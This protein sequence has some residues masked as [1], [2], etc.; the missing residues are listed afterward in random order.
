[1]QANLSTKSTF[2]W[3]AQRI[4]AIFLVFFLC[5]HINFNHLIA[6]ELGEHGYSGL[7]NFQFVQSRL[8]SGS[9]LWSIFYFAFIPICV[10]HAIN[11]L[12]GVI[13]DYRPPELIAK[14]LQAVIVLIGFALTFFG[15]STMF[16]LFGNGGING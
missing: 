12:W 13:A 4:S 11:G 10:F 8:A 16:N 7:I 14:F 3:L 6:W 2:T 1:M 9:T 5:T 15:A